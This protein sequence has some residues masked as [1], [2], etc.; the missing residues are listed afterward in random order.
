MVLQAG[1]T[2]LLIATTVIEVELTQKQAKYSFS[3]RTDSGLRLCISCA[4]AWGVTARLQTAFCN[5]QIR[6]QKLSK[7]SKRLSNAMTGNIL[8]KLI[9][10][11]AGAGDFIGTKQSGASL[12][13]IFSLQMNGEVLKGAKEYADSLSG[14]SVN[15]LLAL[16]HCS[17]A[18]VEDFID[19][20]KQV[21][22]NS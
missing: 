7:D 21:T 9:L 5:L 17:R 15:E 4:V 10:Q 11:C 8:P 16:T 2:K 22:I 1:K 19:K 3:T 6:P 20:I 14:F 18:K 12:T 13:P